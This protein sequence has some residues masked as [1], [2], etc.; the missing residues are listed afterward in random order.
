MGCC[1]LNL[2]SFCFV[3]RALY[4]FTPRPVTHWN[5]DR[6]AWGERR[7]VWRGGVVGR[8]ALSRIKTKRNGLCKY[9]SLVLS[10]APRVGRRVPARGGEGGVKVS[11]TR[12][13]LSVSR[14]SFF[15]VFVLFTRERHTDRR[16]NET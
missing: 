11:N 5:T 1:D 3:R 7:G 8:R 2:S 12:R 6:E 16:T 15:C 14:L 9:L 13:S 4:G 10:V